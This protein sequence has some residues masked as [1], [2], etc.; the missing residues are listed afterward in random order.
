MAVIGGRG[1]VVVLRE[2]NLAKVGDHGHLQQALRR[3]DR[4]HGER[5]EGLVGGLALGDVEFV[6]DALRHILVG[7]GSESAPPDAL[8]VADL[9]LAREDHI[10]RH[11][12]SDAQ[13]TAAGDGPREFPGRYPRAHPTLDDAW[14]RTH[15]HRPVGARQQPAQQQPQH[16]P[17]RHSFQ[18]RRPPA[19]TRGEHDSRSGLE[20]AWEMEDAFLCCELCRRFVV[21]DMSHQLI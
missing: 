21:P 11:A 17:R 3:V 8:W 4:P 13:L 12:R 19:S 10:H 1:V 16:Q 9:Q 14:H 6:Q 7:E 15:R 18:S 5:L 2:P 20:E